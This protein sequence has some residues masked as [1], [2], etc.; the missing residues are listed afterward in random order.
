MHYNNRYPTRKELNKLGKIVTELLEM[1]ERWATGGVDAER[2]LE[3]NDVIHKT[4][5]LYIRARRH[6]HQKNFK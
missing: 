5:A 3:L 4:K 6:F 1:E 2:R